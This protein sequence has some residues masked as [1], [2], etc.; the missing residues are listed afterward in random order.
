MRRFFYFYKM[1]FIILQSFNNYMDAHL[2]MSRLESEE[3]ECWLQDENTVTINPI[4]T[5]AVGGIK[6]LVKKEDFVRARDIFREVERNRHEAVEC[7]KCKGHNVELVSTPRKPGNWLS[8]LWGLF[9]FTFAPPVELA[10]HCFDCGNEFEN[11]NETSAE[12]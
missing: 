3:I 2:L 10:Y 4:L 1:E 6:L 8:A 7:P 12:A 11:V 9:T 5:N